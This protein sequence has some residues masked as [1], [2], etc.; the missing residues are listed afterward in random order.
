MAADN[1]M[2]TSPCCAP[3]GGIVI[4]LPF[5]S[6]CFKSSEAPSASNSSSVQNSPL[7][8]NRS[9]RA[10]AEGKITRRFTRRRGACASAVLTVAIVSLASTNA[11]HVA[12]VFIERGHD[13][14]VAAKTLFLDFLHRLQDALVISRHHLDEFPHHRV[15]VRQHTHSPL[16]LGIS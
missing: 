16:A 8:R 2:I 7:G 12:N 5:H 1:R 14:F 11:R 10:L 13:R 9:K 15:P 4:I 6:S 3:A